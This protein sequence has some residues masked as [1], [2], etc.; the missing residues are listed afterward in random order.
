MARILAGT[1]PARGCRARG[2]VRAS[3]GLPRLARRGP[4]AAR[5]GFDQNQL[6]KRFSH[7]LDSSGLRIAIHLCLWARRDEIYT[8]NVVDFQKSGICPNRQLRNFQHFLDHSDSKLQSACAFRLAEMR[9][10]DEWTISAN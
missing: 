6:S 8:M 9:S 4:G 7:F 1:A 10:S 5:L 2:H 3:A